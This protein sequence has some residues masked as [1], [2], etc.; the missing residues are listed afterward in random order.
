[1]ITR[2]LRLTLITVL[3]LAFGAIAAA[4]GG[5]GNGELTLEEY[6]E[7]LDAIMEDAD[8]RMEALEGPEEMDLA[9][10]EEQLEAI[11]EFYFDANLAIIEG[12]LDEIEGLDPPPEVEE[13]HDALLAAGADTVAAF[14]EVGSQVAEAESLADLVELFDDGRLEAAGEGFEQACLELRGIADENE[15]DV[16]LNCGAGVGA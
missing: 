12:S 1:M 8:S 10:E 16:D 14:E 13:A 9:S 2:F 11:R 7:R 6:F 5:G 3:L 4:C 15:I